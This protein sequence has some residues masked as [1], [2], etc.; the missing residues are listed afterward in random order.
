MRGLHSNWRARK[1][2]DPSITVCRLSWCLFPFIFKMMR[3]RSA[4]QQGHAFRAHHGRDVGS[5][6]RVD[7]LSLCLVV[8]F[9]PV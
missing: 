5:C 4:F 7:D 3:R 8:K 6:M 9:L 1:Q 2:E